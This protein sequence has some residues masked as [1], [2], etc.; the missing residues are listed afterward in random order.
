MACAK[1]AD[2]IADVHL[3]L[4]WI[5]QGPESGIRDYLASASSP[6]LRA[7]HTLVLSLKHLGDPVAF[8]TEIHS[9]AEGWG[10]SPLEEMAL[11]L[12]HDLLT[13]IV[14]EK[15]NPQA[16]SRYLSQTLAGE[17]PQ[18][19][20]DLA[21][22]AQY[23]QTRPPQQLI[24]FP[25]SDSP[26]RSA[27]FKA[28]H[29]WGDTPRQFTLTIQRVIWPEA[30][31]FAGALSGA[32]N[33]LGEIPDFWRNRHPSLCDYEQILAYGDRLYSRWTGTL[34]DRR[35]S[36]FSLI[37]LPLVMQPRP[38]LKLVSQDNDRIN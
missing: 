23:W 5:L 22:I 19:A 6:S 9:F 33:G 15:L 34:G 7:F 13:Q 29:A 1:R 36:H 25:E 24:K 28:I 17:Y 11:Q 30:R 27:I 37:T 16:L 4:N 10:L 3:D 35:L 21:A 12:F 26:W 8:A 38:G 18:L 20:D 31:L 14:L 32:D 2:G